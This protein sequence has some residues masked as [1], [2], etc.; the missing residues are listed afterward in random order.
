MFLSIPVCEVLDA[1]DAVATGVFLDERAESHGVE[2]GQVGRIVEDL[3]YRVAG[4]R[5]PLQLEHNQ[6]A[7]GIDTKEIKRTTVRR[8]LP[9]DQGL[10]LGVHLLVKLK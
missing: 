3:S 9:A 2:S 4:Q 6:P 8:N 1:I 7:V 10:R 5:A